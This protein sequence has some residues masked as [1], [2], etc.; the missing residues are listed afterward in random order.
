MVD[1]V[2]QSVYMY[3]K[4]RRTGIGCFLTVILLA[5]ASDVRADNRPVE[6]NSPAFRMARAPLVSQPL[7]IPMS[8]GMSSNMLA[9]HD[10]YE[11]MLIYTIDDTKR[12]LEKTNLNL[13]H[14]RGLEWLLDVNQA[15]LANHYE[16]LG[17]HS[18]F[19]NS[20]RSN[21]K[22]AWTNMPDPITE[23]LSSDVSR[24]DALSKDPMLPPR[25]RETYKTMLAGYQSKLADHE[26]NAQLWASLHLAE[27]NND[28]Q[29][30]ARSEQQLADYLAVKL[31]ELQGKKY[32]TGMSY[33]AVVE[34]YRIQAGGGRF[35]RRK[36][37]VAILAVT[38]ILP[39]VILIFKLSW[40]R[41]I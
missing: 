5:F 28:P 11:A 25:E 7:Q 22:T 10:A 29:Q 9:A 19:L 20:V 36:I 31:G 2:I 18:N 8:V 3:L 17:K 37:V 4:I 24:Y 26:T 35:D 27:Q 21:P 34:Q 39:V 15:K 14:Q 6:S 32:P 30:V 23:T 40:R 1:P 16:Q 12:Q 33:A 38:A 41:K 13:E